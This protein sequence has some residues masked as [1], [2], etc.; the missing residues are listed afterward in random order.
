MGYWENKDEVYSNTSKWITL[1]NTGT[2]VA[3]KN[4]QGQNVRH[5][6][7]PEAYN[8]T[9]DTITPNLSKSIHPSATN[10]NLVNILGIQLSDVVIPD[11]LASK[12]RKINI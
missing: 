5:H 4:F 8:Y 6:R 11:E 2:P 1:D 3:G 7:F 9:S 12:V 10:Y